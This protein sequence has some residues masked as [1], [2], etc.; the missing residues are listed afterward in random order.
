M[1]DSQQKNP[2]E[3]GSP[4]AH[5]TQWDHWMR[6]WSNGLVADRHNDRV[7]ERGVRDPQ[8]RLQ[9][10]WFSP[11][12]APYPVA[13]TSPPTPAPGVRAPLTFPL[14]RAT[15]APEGG[16][17]QLS[18]SGGLNGTEQR[19]NGLSNELHSLLSAG[20]QHPDCCGL[21]A[22]SA[23]MKLPGDKAKWPLNGPSDLHR[24]L[25]SPSPKSFPELSDVGWT[26]E[27]PPPFFQICTILDLRFGLSNM[28]NTL[29][30]TVLFSL[31]CLTTP[32]SV[33]DS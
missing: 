25:L 9:M 20:E 4:T 23:T 21:S 18:T 1:T 16:R 17:R 10:L 13:L 28:R 26:K 2:T 6:S 24:S 19:S 7:E 22:G 29:G 32:R 11:R 5:E 8:G 27:H 15:P 12:D 14:V 31:L 30:L 3:S 33:G